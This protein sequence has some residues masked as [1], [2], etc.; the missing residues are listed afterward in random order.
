MEFA[1]SEFFGRSKWQAAFAVEEFFQPLIAGT[2]FAPDDF[3]RDAITQFAAMTPAFQ[4]V[5]VAD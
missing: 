2:A 1:V 4:P 3:R 5:F